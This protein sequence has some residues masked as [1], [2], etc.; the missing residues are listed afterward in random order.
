MLSTVNVA[1]YLGRDDK[2]ITPCR[3]SI[4]RYRRIILK[5]H[6]ADALDTWLQT[7]KTLSKLGAFY[8]KTFC[9]KFWK[10][11]IKLHLQNYKQIG[12]T[13]KNHQKLL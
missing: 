10:N 1:V 7:S 12:V 8:L 2:N 6:Y 4:I 13:C 9:F 11:V 5:I 3:S